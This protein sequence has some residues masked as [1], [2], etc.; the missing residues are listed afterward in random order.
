MRS[1]S[2]SRLNSLKIFD[3]AGR[4]VHYGCSQEW[5]ATEWQRHAGC[6]PA[7]VCNIIWYLNRIQPAFGPGR[8]CRRKEESLSFMEEIWAHVTPSAE[9]IPTTRMLHDF[10]KAYAEAKGSNV[11][12]EVC[13]VPETKAG[14]PALTDVARFLEKALS[15]DLPI[16][17][18]NL[19]N[20][21]ESRLESWHWVTIISLAYSED[22]SSACVDILDGGL[23]K[24]IDLA[25]WLATTTRGGGFV[26]FYFPVDP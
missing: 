16:A 13:D 9:G 2:I 21:D 3:D 4:E 15:E 24:T 10:V 25:L 5:Y 11:N 14:R 6:G 20:G 12:Y 23:I 22:G 1:I 19:C 17:F 7:A 18:L 8:D 26:Y